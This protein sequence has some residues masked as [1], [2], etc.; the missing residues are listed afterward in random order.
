M[1]EQTE[2]VLDFILG[3]YN[4]NSVSYNN[5]E[6]E[7][8]SQMCYD[9]DNLSLGKRLNTWMFDGAYET[10][11][12]LTDAVVASLEHG[13]DELLFHANEF[14]K[15]NDG[16]IH[17][18][19]HFEFIQSIDESQIEWDLLT[20]ALWGDDIRKYIQENHMNICVWLTRHPIEQAQ[21]E[22]MQARGFFVKTLTDYANGDESKFKFLSGTQAFELAEQVAGRP[23]TE[24]DVVV[25]VL[26]PAFLPDYLRA[27]GDTPLL[28][29]VMNVKARTESGATYE[30]AGRLERT[31]KV[32]IITE[33]WQF[34]ELTV[35]P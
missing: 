16:Y 18:A 25:G 4:N 3:C 20:E 21:R 5:P 27:S 30:W 2:K 34:S 8:L 28:R 1:N 35:A 32:E 33:D 19:E 31:I 29:A 15:N 17:W 11:Q 12:A 7:V 10:V 22:Y 26:P 23:L 14:E 9:A 24:N 6:R 13:W